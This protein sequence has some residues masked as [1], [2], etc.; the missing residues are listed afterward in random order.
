V[1]REEE[2]KAGKTRKYGS[3]VAVVGFVCLDEIAEVDGRRR[4]RTALS[5][6]LRPILPFWAVALQKPERGFLYI[7]IYIYILFHNFSKIY[8]GFKNL[9]K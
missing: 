9:Q 4:R 5:L 3:A 1:G 2:E 6:G 8:T 7:Y